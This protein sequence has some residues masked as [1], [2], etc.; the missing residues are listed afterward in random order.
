VWVVGGDPVQPDAG[1]C[2]FCPGRRSCEVFFV[3]TFPGTAEKTALLGGQAGSLPRSH[4][5]NPRP[6][7]A[8]AHEDKLRWWVMARAYSGEWTRARAS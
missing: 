3:W 1:F 4:R 6:A 7:A 5:G 8:Q 2:D